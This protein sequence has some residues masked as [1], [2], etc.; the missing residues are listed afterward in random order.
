MADLPDGD[1][2]PLW[3]SVQT[4]LALPM[5]KRR[6]AGH[7]HGTDERQDIL[8]EETVSDHRRNSK[9]VAD[10]ISKGE[11]VT[12]RTERD[13]TLSL[14]DRM[15]HALQVNL[16]AGHRPPSEAGGLVDMKIPV[17]RL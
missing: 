15:L 2:A 1:A 14:P 12:T 4:I 13:K 17:N 11:F 16:R 6:Y 9:R 10:G 7:D 5:E 8:W 3:N